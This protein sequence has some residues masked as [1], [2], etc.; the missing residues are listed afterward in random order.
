MASSLSLTHYETLGVSQQAKPK[1][2]RDAY[3]KLALKLHPDKDPGNPRAVAAFQKVSTSP[4]LLELLCW[5]NSISSMTQLG[6]AY[7]ALRDE[8]RR[9]K[10]DAILSSSQRARQ[11]PLPADWPSQ[12]SSDP[13]AT[14][15][16]WH[17]DMRRRAWDWSRKA[18]E[19]A[20]QARR[21]D[22]EF[23]SGAT[24]AHGA[25]DHSGWGKEWDL[26][27]KDR[28]NLRE[29]QQRQRAARKEARKGAESKKR[30]MGTP[31]PPPRDPVDQG[32]EE[33]KGRAERYKKKQE[34]GE[35]AERER[36]E[37]DENWSKPPSPQQFDPGWSGKVDK[38]YEERLENEKRTRMDYRKAEREQFEKKWPAELLRLRSKI[39][40]IE[41]DIDKTEAKVDESKRTTKD[42]RED[43]DHE[44]IF[45]V[46]IK[47][48]YLE[49][50]LKKCLNEYKQI[51]KLLSLRGR[52]QEADEADVQLREVC[53]LQS[54][55]FVVGNST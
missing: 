18:Q 45:D 12:K 10:Y 20:D 33:F 14:T 2:V 9:T 51:V 11:P 17:E 36:R 55:S 25:T 29:H 41:V 22:D 8:T 49:R 3:H 44:Q 46:S 48:K 37:D 32:A 35:K 7:E 13:D 27:Q 6:A 5:L 24:Y 4:L 1:E 42:E 54:N 16:A 50:R 47:R 43:D 31:P 52:G 26:E 19:R 39:I 53:T 23:W 21:E 30:E 40:S 38:E 34:A 15:H 28:Y